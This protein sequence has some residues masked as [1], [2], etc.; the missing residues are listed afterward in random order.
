MPRGGQISPQPRMGPYLSHHKENQH[1]VYGVS[2]VFY[3]EK[4]CILS[5]GLRGLME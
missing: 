1:K 3:C 5:P 4:Y 2:L